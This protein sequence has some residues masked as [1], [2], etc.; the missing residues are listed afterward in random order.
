MMDMRREVIDQAVRRIKDQ[1]F[2]ISDEEVQRSEEYCLRKMKV[3]GK[4]EDYF[5][6]LF[7]DVLKEYV[8]RKLINTISFLCMMEVEDVQCMFKESL[9]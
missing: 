9:R 5:E 1:G 4:K 2:D 6:I 8:V 7:P 3:A